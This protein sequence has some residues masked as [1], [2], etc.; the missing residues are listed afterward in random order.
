MMCD[1]FRCSMAWWHAVLTTV[2]AGLP[3]VL[4]PRV[5]WAQG[6][7][8]G[9]SPVDQPQLS[10]SPGRPKEDVQ[11]RTVYGT[12]GKDQNLRQVEVLLLT[13]SEQERSRRLWV[14][15]SALAAGAVT[16]PLGF[17]I[18]RHT[19]DDSF[20]GHVVLGL[21]GGQ[22]G[23]GLAALVM[24][25]SGLP[26]LARALEESRAAGKTPAEILAAVEVEWERLAD[27]ARSTR[28]VVG[29]VGLS[30][31]VLALGG[32]SYL[33][34]SDTSG[35]SSEARYNG[36]AAL[37]GLGTLS[38]LGGLQALFVETSV[39]TGWRTYRMIGRT[40]APVIGFTMVPTTGGGM[41]QLTGSF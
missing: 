21:G 34:L 38:L 9:S 24:P 37:L 36:S 27:E 29:I 18:T 26:R 4:A 22:V 1:S 3:G 16:I 32:A 13:Y 35:L 30:I 8:S 17:V 23:G 40:Q 20:V 28:Q 25:E 31:T 14:G 39:E 33:A 12:V 6:S 41:V 11:K 5:V 19:A 7:S 2:L 15:L 10:Q